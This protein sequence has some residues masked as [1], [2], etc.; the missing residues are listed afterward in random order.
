[1]NQFNNSTI[2]EMNTKQLDII[3]FQNQICRPLILDGAMGS[4]LQQRNIPMHKVLWSSYANIIA[5][6]KVTELHQEYITAGADIITTNTFRT[7]PLAYNQAE[8]KISKS[9]L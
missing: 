2:L 6:D 9:V 3:Q 5:P 7:N 4:I 8:L 1:M